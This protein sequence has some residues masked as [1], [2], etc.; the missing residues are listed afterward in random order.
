MEWQTAN[1]NM[2]IS[3]R[4]A[5]MSEE[6]ADRNERLKAAMRQRKRL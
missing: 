1:T 6:H 2:S 5:P 3:L 4:S